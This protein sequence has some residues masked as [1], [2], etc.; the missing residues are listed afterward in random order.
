MTYQVLSIKWRPKNFNDVIGQNHVT[1][2]LANAIKRDRVAH[3]FCF[4]GPRGVG[5]T[6][7]AR[8]LASEL[9]NIESL[10][11]DFDIFEMDAASNRGIDEI[12]NLR[13]NVKILPANSK[14]KIYIIDEV[15]MLTK[16]AFNALLKTLEEPPPHVVFILATTDPHKM[17]STIL[18]RTQ[19]YDFK[20]ISI[21]DIMKQLKLILNSE[22]ISFDESS[23]DVLAQKADG[24]MRDALS[25]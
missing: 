1:I 4:T 13:E 3:A 22:K 19:R 12:R 2:S 8:I 15:H 16:E 14:Y 23:L 17:P 21:Q 10:D 20:R 6:T 7:V 11:A 5:K 24:S 18:S 25:Y 9:N